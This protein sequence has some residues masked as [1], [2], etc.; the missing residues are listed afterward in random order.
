[1]TAEQ[2][3]ADF[4]HLDAPARGAAAIASRPRLAV[5][6]ALALGLVMAWAFLIRVSLEPQ[7]LEG[8]L[9]SRLAQLCVTPTPAQGWPGFAAV[10][11]VWFVM[12]VA[13]MLPSAAPM[14]RTYCDIAEAAAI[15]G[16]SVQHP[17]V[18]VAGY[19]TVWLA[20]SAGFAALAYGVQVAAGVVD[21]VWPASAALAL[22]GAYQFSSLKEACLKK[23]RDP[24][25]TLFARWSTRGRAVFR[26]GL[27]Q[28][29]WCLGCCWALML[30][31]FAVGTMNLLWMALLGL[32]AIV[33]KQETSRLPSRISG[34]ILL[35]WAAALPVFLL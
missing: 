30:V 26:L 33:E 15:K 14:V 2:D 10:T 1:M 6:T 4:P 16:E 13:M 35:V 17:L 7:P 20:A 18:L 22:A 34:T 31:M 19:L 21:S 11:L 32:L 28:G 8:G 25:T 29:L 27:E 5:Y 23:C 9:L 3:R 24:F 12:S